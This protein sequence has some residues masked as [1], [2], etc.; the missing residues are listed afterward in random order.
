MDIATV[1]G[2]ISAPE[3]TEDLIVRALGLY[4]EW[5][6][7]EQMLIAPLLRDKDRIWDAGAFLGTFGI[8]LTQLARIRPA[9][10]VAV[11]PNP[12]I[13]P[14]LKR[15][16]AR[17][18]TC[19]VE[20]APF[21]VGDSDITLVRRDETGS[22]NA[23]GISYQPAPDNKGTI[24]AKTL[25]ELRAR[26]GDYDFLK[27]DVEG[28]E[29]QALRGDIE[30][31]K[32][33]QPVIWAEC[34]EAEESIALLEALV[35]LGYEPLYVAFPAF[36]AA[37]FNGNAEKMY[38]I[39]YE[40]GL[41][42]A[43]KDRLAAFTGKVPGEDIIVRPV[44]TSFDLRKELFITP[45]WGQADWVDMSKAELIATLGRIATKQELVNFLN[46]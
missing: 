23:G 34:N 41:L 13:L 38:P 25:K 20:V 6:F 43:P 30:Y 42:A 26:F 39:A 36:R 16:L 2:Q 33:R 29:N 22:G 31:L 5:S 3:T 15:N 19:P 21:A 4:G 17:N 9:N 1:Y 11:E 32:S 18:L 44:K 7:A 46:G 27:L 10:L 8:G 12:D 14:H 24:A 37:N 45:R 28:M 35:W 40:A